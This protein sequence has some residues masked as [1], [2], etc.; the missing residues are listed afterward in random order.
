MSDVPTTKCS[1]C[2]ALL[3]EEDLFCAN[4]GTA[5]PQGP[6]A[7]QTAAS[8]ATASSH[9]AL[10]AAAMRQST[11]G[12]AASE[13]VPSGSPPPAP[14]AH[15]VTC[16]FVCHGCGASMSYDASAG[17]L[18]CPFCGSTELVKQPDAKEIAPEGVVP[19][20]IPREQAVATMRKWLG[21]SIWRPGDLS[22]QAMVVSM[23]PVFVPFWVFEAQ[24]HTYWTADSSHTP[25]NACASWYPVSGQHEG[26]Y[27]GLLVG[28][29]GVLTTAETMAICPFDLAPALPPDKV[30]LQ[31][32]TF[33]RFSVPRKYARPLASQGFETLESEECEHL[34]PGRARNVRVN[35]RITD[36]TS[37]PMLLPVWIM[38]Y[39]YQNRVFRF[40]LNGQTGRATGQAPVS[41]YRIGAAI[42]AA[43]AAVLLVLAFLFL[44]AKHR[45]ESRQFGVNPEGGT[46]K[47]TLPLEASSA[48]SINT[49]E[50]Q[51]SR[52][53]E[54][55]GGPLGVSHWQTSLVSATRFG[56]LLRSN[57]AAVFVEAGLGWYTAGSQHPFTLV[58]IPEFVPRARF[59]LCASRCCNPP[60]P[61]RP[62]KISN[63]APSACAT[64]WAS[65]PCTND[66]K[67]PSTPLK[68]GA[69]RWGTFCSTARLAWA[70]PHSP[71]A[72]HATWA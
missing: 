62:R 59:E 53:A 3:D 33:E 20:V 12:S 35:V 46:G 23:T 22:A 69:K 21:N 2:G 14:P 58:A 5:A 29:S 7:P 68:N 49:S 16:N 26:Q 47:R 9:S 54:K 65:G 6:G 50:R 37:Q 42:A 13:T 10:S 28:A 32:A 51:R 15:E 43:V 17:A 52:P 67:S 60:I 11:S 57:S 18:R 40:L 1:I 38:A 72:F 30:D 61:H 39:R 25:H 27:D 8:A 44:W 31:N 70:K 19:F 55:S 48:F 36:L 4:C 34:V 64:W 45:S 71:P 24:T 41:W 56:R 63:C 66:W